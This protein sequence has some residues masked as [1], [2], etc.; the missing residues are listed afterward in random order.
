MLCLLEKLFRVFDVTSLFNNRY[1]ADVKYFFTNEVALKVVHS[2]LSH[3]LEYCPL[4]LGLRDVSMYT[5]IPT[6]TPFEKQ[7]QQQT[8]HLVALIGTALLS[9]SVK[10][11]TIST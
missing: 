1:S 7:Q 3:E 11:L 6:A 8:T 10:P 9:L 5:T 2:G 4:F